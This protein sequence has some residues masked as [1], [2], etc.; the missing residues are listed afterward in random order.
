MSG[1]ANNW[2]FLYQGME[3]EFTDP[4]PYYY[5]GTGQFYSPQ[6]MRSPSETGQ[7]S[8]SGSGGGGGGGGGFSPNFSLSPQEAGEAMGAGVGGMAVTAGAIAAYN[9]F[10]VGSEAGSAGLL[11]PVV[12]VGLIAEGLFELFDD[13]FGGGS[14]PEIPRQLL[15]K[16]HPLYPFILGVSESLVPSEASE[17]KPELCGDPEYCGTK[18]LEKKTPEYRAAPTA[19]PT[20]TPK[21]P[22]F[23]FCLGAAAAFNPAPFVGCPAGIMGCYA[24]NPEGCAQMATQCSVLGGTI[25]LCH[26][27]ASGGGR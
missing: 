15:H 19:T 27:V 9:A 14:Q 13:L 21:A 23:F 8:S 22:G 18:P 5:T 7:T 24:A 10:L 17:G 12:V 26:A 11:T 2:P 20:A 16:R 25:V 1:T 4:G 3:K 6:I